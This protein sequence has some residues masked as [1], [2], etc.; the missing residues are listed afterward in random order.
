MRI[1]KKRRL[2][3]SE[4]ERK[5]RKEIGSIYNKLKS[6]GLFPEDGLNR[7]IAEYAVEKLKTYEMFKCFGLTLNRNGAGVPNVIEMKTKEIV[8]GFENAIVGL[9]SF[10]YEYESNAYTPAAAFFK[11]LIHRL[12]IGEQGALE[13]KYYILELLE[14]VVKMKKGNECSSFFNENFNT[15]DKERASMREA[16][17]NRSSNGDKDQSGEQ[18]KQSNYSPM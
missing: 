11:E 13:D 6:F 16:L 17:N 2:I 14:N 9:K 15:F 18:P 5:E 3:M 1:T 7:I 4:K 12:T 10:K 8:N